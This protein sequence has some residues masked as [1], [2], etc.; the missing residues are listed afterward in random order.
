M[1]NVILGDKITSE[2]LIA[3]VV[4]N[5]DILTADLEYGGGLVVQLPFQ[6]VLPLVTSS[7]ITQYRKVVRSAGI[8]TYNTLIDVSIPGANTSFTDI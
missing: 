3:V 7:T 2:N 1:P 8:Q 6:D 4:V 5:L